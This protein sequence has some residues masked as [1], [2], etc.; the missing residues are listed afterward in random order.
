MVITCLS[1]GCGRINDSHLELNHI[2]IGDLEAAAKEAA[3]S[4]QQ[5]AE[6]IVLT[7]N[8]AIRKTLW[9][10]EPPAYAEYRL[11]KSTEERQFTLGVAYPA[12]KP[13]MG[14]AADGHRD[15]VGPEALE[16]TAHEWLAKYRDVSMFH[17]DGTS[18]HFTPAE[19]YLWPAPDWVT[20][21][22][23]DGKEYRICKGDWLLGGYWDDY[24]WAAVKAKLANGWSPQ[25]TAKRSIASAE[26]L[27]Q[28]RS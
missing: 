19:S 20:V 2:T 18:G 22:P 16:K 28:L 26:R 9:L 25:G 24:G 12:M 6:N 1:C 5:A 11:V 14:R 21:S 7:L 23:V 17:K 13:D 4:L 27:K 3:I 8:G 10:P 15:F